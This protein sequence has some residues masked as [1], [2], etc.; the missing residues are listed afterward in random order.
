MDLLL[1]KNSNYDVPNLPGIGQ[2]LS[3]KCLAEATIYH[4]EQR[5]TNA[6]GR[7]L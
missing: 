3:D 2:G 7:L 6:K 4:I 1:L 5:D